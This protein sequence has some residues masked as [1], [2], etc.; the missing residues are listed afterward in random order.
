MINVD[1]IVDSIRKKTLIA[2][3]KMNI[4]FFVGFFLFLLSGEK[5]KKPQK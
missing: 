2:T 4:P 3:L 1:A 5:T